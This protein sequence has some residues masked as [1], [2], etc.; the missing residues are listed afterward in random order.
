[1]RHSLE[2]EE[3]SAALDLVVLDLPKKSASERLLV[4]AVGEYA[5]GAHAGHAIADFLPVRVALSRR[6]LKSCFW[7]ISREN[8]SI[9]HHCS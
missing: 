9:N 6:Y 3:V 5:V 8:V 4:T 1:M 2:S 7:T